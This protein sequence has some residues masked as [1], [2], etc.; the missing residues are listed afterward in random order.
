M[1][2]K[3]S[4]L[5]TRCSARY[6]VSSSL[7]ALALQ[8]A[9]QSRTYHQSMPDQRQKASKQPQYIALVALLFDPAG[10]EDENRIKAIQELREGHDKAA[11]RWAPHVTIVPPFDVRY[12]EGLVE[13]E[14]PISEQT[15]GTDS[16]SVRRTSRTYTSLDLRAS[17][18]E[19]EP[20]RLP[21]DIRAAYPPG[22]KAALGTFEEH[23]EKAVSS[24]PPSQVLLDEV[25]FF[26]LRAYHT[27]HL[28]PALNGPA[29]PLHRL[30]SAVSSSLDSSAIQMKLPA[31]RARGPQSFKPHLTLGQS[32]TG[33]EKGSIMNRAKA[34]VETQ[35]LSCKVERFQLLFK[36]K[37]QSGPYLVWREFSLKKAEAVNS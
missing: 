31:K 16:S 6:L 19:T 32:A 23:I 25:G 37:S 34:I 8:E 2:L 10:P 36:N 7:K 21:E 18:P 3:A 14:L 29:E 26:P 11:N 5:P 20:Y 30:W 9:L 22:L 15:A 24:I 13:D 28:R 1:F 12:E 4:L 27:I 35:P 33:Q 17:S